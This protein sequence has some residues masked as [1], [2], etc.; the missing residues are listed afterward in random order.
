M[1]YKI[2]LFDLDGTLTD[3]KVG[4]TKSVQYALAKFNINEPNLDKLI[5]FIGPPLV[6]SFQEFYGL[7]P[8]AAADGVGY[9]REYFTKTGMFENAVYPGIKELLTQ[10]VAQGKTLLVATSKPTVYSQQILEHF[11]LTGFFQEVVGSNLDGTRIHKA[12]IIAYILSGLTG[13]ER[14]NIVMV[15]DR[16]HDIIGAQ[17]NDIASIAV[18][19][20]YGTEAELIAAKPTYLAATIAE[21]SALLRK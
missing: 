17:K 14:R 8:A 19:Y 10:L 2:I 11:G 12:E 16:M 20:G 13:V 3:P 5:P 15:G 21:L 1:S 9:Y 6:E 4:I 18:K 7:S